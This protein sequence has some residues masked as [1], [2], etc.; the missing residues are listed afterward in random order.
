VHI[1]T[2]EKTFSPP[3][4]AAMILAK[5][6][7]DAGAR[8]G[9]EITKAVIAVPAFF[10]ECQRQAIIEAGRLAGLEVPRIINEASAAA[11]AIWS[12][13]KKEGIIAVYAF[14]GGNSECSVLQIDDDV[15][16]VRSTNADLHLGG[17]EW[18][19]RI[20]DWV[21]T[22]FERDTGI[23]LR[24]NSD[25]VYRIKEEAEKAKI[26]LSSARVYEINLPFIIVDQTGPKHILLE[27]SRAKFEALCD[28]LLQRSIQL[29]KNCFADAKMAERELDDLV[30]VGGMSRI[31]GV[32]D[33]ARKLIGKE[34][35]KGVNPD[36]G[37]AI[38][39]AF[40]GGVCSGLVQTLLLEVSSL[41]LTIKTSGKALI[42]LI[43]RNA[44]LPIRTSRKLSDL[45][46]KQLGQNLRV[47][48]G[49]P[50]KWVEQV[51][52]FNFA[53]IPFASCEEPH[54][55]VTFA[56]DVNGMLSVSAKD[57]D[58]GTVYKLNLIAS[59]RLIKL[60]GEPTKSGHVLNRL[61]RLFGF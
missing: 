50:A 59:Q 12:N 54:A 27:L 14:G 17:E 16:E 52:V 61:K 48:Q 29:L 39:A 38:G 20:A 15:L 57:L 55:E 28:D 31:P 44:T 45:R 58:N 35:H 3:E 34:P 2:E 40:L 18:D 19:F 8:L 46:D 41:A 37:V 36:E 30:L 5:L 42:P 9:E 4:I 32:M 51:A 11:C 7:A 1:G 53:E 21:I 13:T 26:T 60:G 56:I 23:D 25:A 49:D 43:S 47:L 24:Q 6:K 10:N 33:A 22:E